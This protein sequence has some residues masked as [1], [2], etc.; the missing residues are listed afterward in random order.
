MRL[1]GC[2]TRMGFLPC[3]SAGLFYLQCGAPVV[4][5]GMREDFVPPAVISVLQGEEQA[6]R[7]EKR[8]G[9]SACLGAL[10]LRG[11]DAIRRSAP[12]CFGKSPLRTK[13]SFWLVVGAS[14]HPPLMQRFTH[15]KYSH[16]RW[17]VTTVVTTACTPH[18]RAQE[19][20]VTGGG[21]AEH[22]R[23]WGS[24]RE[25]KGILAVRSALPGKPSAA[26]H[27][28]RAAAC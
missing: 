13:A 18:Q 16:C 7:R 12:A 26:R 9:C 24:G 5:R 27:T 1:S 8:E 14:T 4:G 3:N 15:T 2:K 25:H 21:E 23:T 22:G 28:R 20:G 17:T 19:E 6:K 11:L 10:L